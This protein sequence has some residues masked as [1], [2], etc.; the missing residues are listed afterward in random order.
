MSSASLGLSRGKLRFHISSFYTRKHF[1]DIKG[2]NKYIYLK[3]DD[4]DKNRRRAED[5]LDELKKD[6]EEGTFN[7]YDLDRYHIKLYSGGIQ[8][9]CFRNL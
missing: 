1:P 7:P 9:K 3:V 6:L 5:K 8:Q 2:G 4:T